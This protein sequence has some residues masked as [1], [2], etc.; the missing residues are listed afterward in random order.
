MNCKYL[1]LLL[2]ILATKKKQEYKVEPVQSFKVNNL[3]ETNLIKTFF[4]SMFY[5]VF[6]NF[7]DFILV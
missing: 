6:E 2:A 4:C 3:N 1:Y 7:S 5:R